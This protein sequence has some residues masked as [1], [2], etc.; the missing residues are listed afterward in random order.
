[1]HV[2]ILFANPSHNANSVTEFDFLW[3]ANA[4]ANFV[5]LILRTDVLSCVR[6]TVPK[7]HTGEVSTEANYQKYI[8]SRMLLHCITSSSCVEC[9]SVEHSKQNRVTKTLFARYKLLRLIA[10]V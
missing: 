7:S 3:R 2:R 5:L 8:V 4:N 9:H 6:G 10:A 1:M